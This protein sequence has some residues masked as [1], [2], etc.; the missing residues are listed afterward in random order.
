MIKIAYYKPMT[1]IKAGEFNQVMDY[2]VF[3]KANEGE[4]LRDLLTHDRS[5]YLPRL[6]IRERS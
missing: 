4:I 6:I 1:I 3:V 2:T 5:H